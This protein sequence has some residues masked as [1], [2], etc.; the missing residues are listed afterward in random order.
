M[1][2][3]IRRSEAIRVA[4]GYCHWT[5]IPAELAKLPSVTP[6]PKNVNDVLEEI[7]ADLQTLADDEWSQKVLASKGLEIAIDYI[8]NYQMAMMEGVKKNEN[9]S[10]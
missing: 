2:D 1:D 9:K 8:E 5:N 6:A 3:L 4:S 10:L 7:K